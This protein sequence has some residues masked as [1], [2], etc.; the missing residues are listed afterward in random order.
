M[1]ARGV[2]VCAGA[3]VVVA[4]ALG[5]PG[6]SSASAHRPA[7]TC[8]PRYVRASLSCG[9]KCLHAGQFCRVGSSEYHRY[10]FDCPRSGRLVSYRGSTKPAPHSRPT[11]ATRSTGTVDVGKTILL[12]PRTKS[13]DCT[14]GPEP[15]RR[16]SPGAYYS[17]LTK[18][19]I[20]SSRF[21]TSTIRH[22]PDSEKFTVE[23]EYGMTPGRYGSSLEIDHIVSL[24]LGG[25]NDPA[26][27][28]PEKL[29]AHPGYR[30][31]DK[32]ETKL[33]ELVCSGSINLR[34]AQREIASDWEKLYKRVQGIT[35]P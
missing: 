31:K 2:F 14:L 3:G 21:H 26:N 18:K 17:R 11:T 12:A 24:E 27:L 7:R 9:E 6:N 34:K 1:T 30:V 19:V 15:D 33:H 23:R 32:L 16:C 13:A 8:G 4:L 25:S 35:P 29:Y 20:C 5:G 28:F 10:G 22:V